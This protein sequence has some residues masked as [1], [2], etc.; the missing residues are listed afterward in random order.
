[1]GG[2]DKFV[3]ITSGKRTDSFAFSKIPNISPSKNANLE[4]LTK[5]EI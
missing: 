1:M 4:V 5:V 2:D 3:S